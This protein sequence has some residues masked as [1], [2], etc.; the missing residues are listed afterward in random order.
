MNKKNSKIKIR[1]LNLG[2]ILLFLSIMFAIL[3]VVF[4]KIYNNFILELICILISCYCF[5]IGGLLVIFE[6]E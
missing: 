4:S 5:L 1:N 3:T 2:M 6:H